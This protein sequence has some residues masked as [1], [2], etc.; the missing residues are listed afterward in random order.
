MM[1]KNTP[2]SLAILITMQMWRYDAGHINQLRASLA[3]LEATWVALPRWLAW[4]TILTANT[5]TLT[6]HNF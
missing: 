1:Q 5:K 2:T 6:K 4:S 3:L